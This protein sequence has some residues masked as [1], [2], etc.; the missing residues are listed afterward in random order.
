M[1]EGIS[2]AHMPGARMPTTGG[3]L[4]TSGTRMPTTGAHVSERPVGGW[5]AGLTLFA[6]VMMMLAGIFGGL[7]G[8][9]ALLENRFYVLTGAYVYELDVTTWGWLHLLV[10]V[11]IA[12]TGFFVFSG[13]PWA[14][15][16]GIACAALNALVN[17]L[18]IPYYPVW[19]LL[20]IALD[21]A[22]IWA[23]ATYARSDLG[24]SR[25]G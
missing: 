20:I 6:S 17:F 19:S 25:T 16:V 5:V 9:A 10:G 14:C 18:F 13:Q 11:A 3:Q 21:V 2:G 15:A 7:A 1:S 8:L 22:V 24:A 12:V 4:P 23:L